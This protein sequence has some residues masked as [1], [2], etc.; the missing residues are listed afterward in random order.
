[1]VGVIIFYD[2]VYFVG[3]FVKFFNIDVSFNIFILEYVCINL[4]S[5]FNVGFF[6]ILNLIRSKRIMI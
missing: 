6:F 4:F 2:Y 3:V 1:M 5:I